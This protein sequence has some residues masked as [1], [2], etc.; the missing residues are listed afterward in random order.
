METLLSEK[1]AFSS[2]EIFNFFLERINEMS[3]PL[4]FII[5][6]I[7]IIIEF[8]LFFHQRWALNQARLSSNASFAAR[9]TPS[10]SGLP[11]SAKPW[12]CPGNT[13]HLENSF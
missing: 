11:L 7:I 3:F 5:I 4:L 6:I 2:P 12:V 8:G 9:T 13:F 1:T 10:S